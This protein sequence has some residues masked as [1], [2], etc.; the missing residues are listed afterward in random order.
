MPLSCDVD[1]DFDYYADPA[2]DFSIM[3]KDCKCGS[4]GKKIQAEE[5]A[6]SFTCYRQPDEE[7][8]DPEDIRAV[9]DGDWYYMPNEY[10][11]ESCGEIYMN[12]TAI[13]YEVWNGENMPE[14]LAEYQKMTGFNPEKYRRIK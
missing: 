9:E 4:C 12:L 5:I 6:L 3:D 11:C 13:G 7:S 2:D 1:F 14:L 10:L 8:E